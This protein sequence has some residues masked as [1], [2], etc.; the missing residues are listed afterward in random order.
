MWQEIRHVSKSV[1]SLVQKGYKM[2]AFYRRGVSSEEAVDRNLG[3]EYVENAKQGNLKAALL[4]SPEA[5]QC[6]ATSM[7]T[8]TL[9]YLDAY[10][11]YANANPSA[12]VYIIFSVSFLQL[13]TTTHYNLDNVLASMKTHFGWSVKPSPLGGQL[14]EMLIVTDR[15]EEETQ[16]GILEAWR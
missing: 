3:E 9:G 6:C 15:A 16:K 8:E 13:G 2:R 10:I 7:I 5:S 12:G 4:L 14:F 11:S 1:E